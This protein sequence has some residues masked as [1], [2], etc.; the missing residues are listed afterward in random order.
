[1]IGSFSIAVLRNSTASTVRSTPIMATYQAR[2]GARKIAINTAA[3]R[4]TISSRR[5]A[6]VLKP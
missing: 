1:M 4:M 3:A 6:S 2:F 5:A